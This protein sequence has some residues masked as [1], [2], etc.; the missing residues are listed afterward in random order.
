[1]IQETEDA[2]EIINVIW[3]EKMD[4]DLII[5]TAGERRLS[6]FLL[7]QSAYSELYFYEHPWPDFS[8]ED[9]KIALS[10]YHGRTRKF[11]SLDKTE[12]L[13]RRMQILDKIEWVL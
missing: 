12:S 13:K 9:F 6:N 4:P 3:S 5:R 11:G 1:M 8:I 7:W 2:D 10:D